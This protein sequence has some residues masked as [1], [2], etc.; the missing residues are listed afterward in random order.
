[1][2][3]GGHGAGLGRSIGWSARCVSTVSS[4]VSTKGRY[5][6]ISGRFVADISSFLRLEIRHA[7]FSM[8]MSIVSSPDTPATRVSFVGWYLVGLQGHLL[9]LLMFWLMFDGWP[10]MSAFVP[11]SCNGKLLQGP[12]GRR[13]PCNH[14][15]RVCPCALVPRIRRGCSTS[16]LW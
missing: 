9:R 11:S 5:G 4:A 3:D 14:V 12:I 16:L 15:C 13:H 6:W 2:L 7:V 1:M 10:L 8:V